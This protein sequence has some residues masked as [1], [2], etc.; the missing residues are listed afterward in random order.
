MI[1]QFLPKSLQWK[2]TL[3]YT[4]VTVG[5][6]LVLELGLLGILVIINYWGYGLRGGFNQWHELLVLFTFIVGVAFAS[7]AVLFVGTI[8]FG[9]L[10]GFITARLLL[11]RRIQALAEAATAYSYGDFSIVPKDKSEDELG[12]LAGRLRRMAA[13]LATLLETRQELATVEARNRLARDLHDTVKQQIF[14]LQMQVAAAQ[15]LVERDP[16][17]AKSHISEANFLAQQ[18]QQELKTLIDE[19]RPAALDDKGLASAVRNYAHTWQQLSGI[20][21]EVGVSGERSLS[22]VREQALYRILQESL[23][24]VAKHSG[25]STVG[26][27]LSYT[28][29][30]I[31]LTV[32]DNGLGFNTNAAHSEGFGLQSMHQRAEEL[33]GRLQIQSESGRGTKIQAA[34]P[35]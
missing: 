28:H 9:L 6:L 3:S 19:L 14:A 10:F 32:Q 25:A 31:T 2:L 20:A 11:T 18:A 22:L 27:Q 13:E 21:T 5:T 1:K 34:L 17:S 29:N 12:F 35:I 33:G 26:I 7:G 24:N 23:A 30:T 8:P 16:T 4:L 15:A